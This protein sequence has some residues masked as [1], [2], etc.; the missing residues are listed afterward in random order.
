[1]D[2][3]FQEAAVVVKDDSICLVLTCKKSKVSDKDV[4]AVA[5]D[6]NFEKYVPNAGIR[7]QIYKLIETSVAVEARSA[8]VK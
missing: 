4:I 3:A 8:G 7:H 5:G 1:M 2:H 6:T